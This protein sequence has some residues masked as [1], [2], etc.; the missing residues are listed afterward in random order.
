M[1]GNIFT[2]LEAIRAFLSD[3]LADAVPSHLR[4]EVRACAK[5][6]ANIADEADALPALLL[7]EN[8]AMLLLADDAITGLT[9]IAP[10]IKIR[11]PACTLRHLCEPPP[12]SLR[13]L[14]RLHE[15]LKADAEYILLQVD[16]LMS[17]SDL[18][19]P[20]RASLQALQ[21][22]Y[23]VLLTAQAN[24]RMPWQSVFP[25]PDMEPE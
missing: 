11:T 2:S 19:E 3:E 23:F 9:S 20:A 16:K 14:I 8:R 4:S 12:A 10:D 22:R 7:V 6:L 18:D 25:H 1:S 5:L 13:G 15:E 17:R 24:A 21:D